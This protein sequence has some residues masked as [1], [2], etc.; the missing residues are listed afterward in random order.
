MVYTGYTCMVDIS[1]YYQVYMYIPGLYLVYD[2][3]YFPNK[4]FVF[5]LLNGCLLSVR[6]IYIVSLSIHG[7]SWGLFS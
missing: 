2:K 1:A 5:I 3:I 6:P 7:E 4:F